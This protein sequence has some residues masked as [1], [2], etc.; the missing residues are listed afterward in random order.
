MP[1]FGAEYVLEATLDLLDEF[2]PGRDRGDGRGARREPREG[3]ATL[4]I[5]TLASPDPAERAGI[6]VF[7]RPDPEVI[8]A[9]LGRHRIVVWGRDGRVRLS[10]HLYTADADV[11][12]ALDA[13][14]DLSDRGIRS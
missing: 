6:L 14:A 1:A 9:E 4:G 12:R 3:L 5:E 2:G 11:D 13:I 10:P 7:E 8:A